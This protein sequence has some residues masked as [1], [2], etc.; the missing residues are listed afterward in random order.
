MF[1]A[2]LL[3][4]SKNICFFLFSGEIKRTHREEMSELFT[5]KLNTC[6]WCY[7]SKVTLEL[8]CHPLD[9][10]LYIPS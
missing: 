8:H 3:K 1:P 7:N 9:P 5:L 10:I 6:K 2:D 4:A